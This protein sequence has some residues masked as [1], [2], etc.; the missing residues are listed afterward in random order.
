VAEEPYAGA[1]SPR[2]AP[3]AEAVAEVNGEPIWDAEVAAYAGAHALSPREALDALI[4]LELLAQ[5]ARRRGLSEDPEVVEVRRRER[6]RRLLDGFAAAT[7]S[8]DEIPD[9]DIDKV[10]NRPDVQRQLNHGEQHVVV[11][12]RVPVTRRDPPA[13]T[14]EARRHAEAVRAFLQQAK[15]ADEKDLQQ[16]AREFYRARSGKPLASEK[17]LVVDAQSNLIPVFRDAALALKKPGQ[18]SPVTRTPYGWDILYL[19]EII[20]P[21][22]TT[23]AEAGPELRRRVH[24]DWRR[25][26]FSRWLE[27][28]VAAARITRR[29]D[30]LAQVEVDSTFGLP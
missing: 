27:A 20:P 22:T 4:D 29:D 8:P 28:F 16:Q 23:R 2:P 11:Y 14:E 15:I 18:V 3:T 26:T 30:G 7:D 25:Y 19:L 24:E 9:A 17:P 1:W 10:W 21:R 13:W 5:E 12:V 6:V